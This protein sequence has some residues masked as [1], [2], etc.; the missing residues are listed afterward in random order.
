MEILGNE[1]ANTKKDKYFRY[2]N[3]K[4]LRSIPQ[5]RSKHF[6]YEK[7]SVM[8]KNVKNSLIALDKIN[9]DRQLLGNA[10]VGRSVQKG[11]K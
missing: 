2:Y 11:F 8:M 7:C 6:Y 1:L 9:G 10:L 5:S 4:E 3:F